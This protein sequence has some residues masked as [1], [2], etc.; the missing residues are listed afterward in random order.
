MTRGDLY[1]ADVPGGRHPVAIVTRTSALPSLRDILVA[2]ITSTHRDIPSHAAVG[3]EHGLRHESYANCDALVLVPT[4]RLT[5]PI[6]R[7]DAA[8]QA[9]LNAALRFALEL[10]EQP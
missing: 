1:W 4:S 2:P 7:L 8:A 9:R 10:E 6:G 3:P 5:E